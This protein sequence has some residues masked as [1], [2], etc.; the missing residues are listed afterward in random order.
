MFPVNVVVTDALRP[1]Y[2]ILGISS[3]G[4]RDEAGRERVTT[5]DVPIRGDSGGRLVYLAGGGSHGAAVL[6]HTTGI[7]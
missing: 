2:A 5:A 7:G 4:G 3:E 1:E 6:S